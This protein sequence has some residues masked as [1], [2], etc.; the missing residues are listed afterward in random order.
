[1]RVRPPLAERTSLGQWAAGRSPDF[2]NQSQLSCS[3]RVGPL[4][5][6]PAAPPGRSADLKHTGRSTS[7]IDSDSKGGGSK[8][9]GKKSD[10]GQVGRGTRSGGLF[11]CGRAKR[12]ED[13]VITVEDGPAALSH[14][15]MLR[16]MTQ[17]LQVAQE[18]EPPNK[19]V[20]VSTVVDG[21]RLGR[22]V[23]GQL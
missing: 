4:P 17:V 19:G 2:A 21:G 23:S 5:S 3:K 11:C 22:T 18:V 13:V 16:G 20:G 14:S 15:P 9:G 7:L 10:G 6:V 1:M 12:P 8:G